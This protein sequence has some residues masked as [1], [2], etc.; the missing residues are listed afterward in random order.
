[1]QS[2]AL[3]QDSGIC[4]QTILDFFYPSSLLTEPISADLDSRISPQPAAASSAAAP[5]QALPPTSQ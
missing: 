3:L 4:Q 1:M 5:A 2:M